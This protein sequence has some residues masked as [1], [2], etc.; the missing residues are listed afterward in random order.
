MN[1]RN[2]R[3]YVRE[4]CERYPNR[5]ALATDRVE[6]TFDSLADDIR[7]IAT[8]LDSLGIGPE[9]FVGVVPGAAPEVLYILR[10]ATYEHGAA[11]FGID[12]A[13]SPD[14]LARSVRDIAPKVVIYDAHAWPG[15]PALLSQLLP[16][17]RAIAASGP[18]GEYEGLLASIEGRWSENP[19]D[20]AAYA[21]VGFTSGTTGVPKGIT[22]THAAL[23]ESC[24]MLMRAFESNGTEKASGMFNAVPLFAAG[25]GMIVPALH[26]GMTMYLQDRFDADRMVDLIER[27]RIS[28]ALLTPSQLIDMLDVPDLETRDLSSLRLVMYGSAS[29]PA[30]KVEEAVRRLGP[31]FL[32]GYGMSE[33]L[34][35]VSVLWPSEHGVREQPAPRDVLA[36]AGRPVDGVQ[37]RIATPNGSASTAHNPGE[38]VIL[39][40][41]VTRGYW[42]AP[43][44]TAAALRDGWWHSGD[45]GYFDEEGRL[46]ILDRKQDVLERN[47]HT[48]YPREIEE[49]ASGHPKVKEVCVVQSSEDG[50]IVAAASLR[51]PYRDSAAAA[52]VAAE[53]KEFLRNALA[54]EKLPDE[55]VIFP[56]LPRS[57]QGKVLKREVRNA[58]GGR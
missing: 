17:A 41:N 4:A 40:P 21:A 51:R 20:P 37:V 32:Q 11:L 52:S 18:K 8:L 33:C 54:P 12:P 50:T 43:D 26:G 45:I 57:I 10:L 56:E 6:I 48:L 28:H 31:V 24:R 1:E 5:V 16:A 14:V 46:H 42:G 49:V 36:S 13:L 7:K 25:G 27:R 34:P 53:I 44:L 39:S 3:D 58:V 19:I 23:A 9:D 47:G 55:V 35:P 22:S 38:I 15:A 29:L 30:A 2:L